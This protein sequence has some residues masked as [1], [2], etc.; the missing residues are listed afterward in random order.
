MI[1][2]TILAMAVAATAGIVGNARGT[3][4]RARRR[5]Q[6]QHL[7]TQAVEF[8]L[9][10]GPNAPAIP[11]ILPDGY[12]ATCT[13]YPVEDLEESAL[14]P[15]GGWILCEYAITLIGPDGNAIAST[16]VRKVLKEEDAE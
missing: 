1:A 13:V 16:N 8:Y 4:L 6:E 10:G 14:E 9:L 15:I 12:S 5:W 3:L 11:N 2:A 7:L